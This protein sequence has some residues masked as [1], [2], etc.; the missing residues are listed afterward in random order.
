MKNRQFNASEILNAIDE[1]N[2]ASIN[3]DFSIKQILNLILGK[4]AELSGAKHGQ[5]LLYDGYDL[6]I[7]AATESAGLEMQLAIDD[8]LCGEVIRKEKLFNVADVEKL[9]RFSRF[10]E[11]TVSELAVPL[12]YGGRVIGVINLES[13]EHNAF[14]PE[15]E[16]IITTLAGQAATTIKTASLYSQQKTLAA[17]KESLSTSEDDSDKIYKQIISGALKLINGR[18]GQLLLVEGE[19][20][21][22]AA[23]TGREKPLATRVGIDGCI[24]GMAIRSGEAVNIPD[25]TD[26]KYSNLYKSYLGEMKSELAIPIKN[27]DEVVGV[28]NFEH[29]A[30]SFFTDEHI[31]ILQNMANISAIAI[32]NY[33]TEE[34]M[35]RNIQNVNALIK[36]LESYPAKIESMIGS[37]KEVTKLLTEKKEKSNPSNGYG[38]L[39]PTDI[40]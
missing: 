5:V 16:K 29:P 6:K 23:T 39:A 4:A 17:L 24:S 2:Q 11:D 28:L 38:F 22:I 21:V 26:D 25:V 12:K 3:S 34:I 13:Y 14:S 9:D 37:I 32:T 30:K 8:C 27:G 33:Q 15:I 40:Y 1:I 20:L 10:F 31:R 19:D 18:S 7:L 35:Q 36:E